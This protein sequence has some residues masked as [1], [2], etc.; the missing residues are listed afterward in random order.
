MWIP[1]TRRRHGRD[2]SRYETDLIDAE[3]ALIEP[4]MPKP[5]ARGRPRAWHVREIVN[6]IF[7]ALRDG[8]HGGSC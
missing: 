6:A 3:W 4:F 5:L 2:G 7:Y 8:L 1:T